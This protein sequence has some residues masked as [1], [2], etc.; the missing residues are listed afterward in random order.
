MN[1]KIVIIALIIV[2]VGGLVVGGIVFLP[3]L[4]NKS[5]EPIE[6]LNNSINDD[7]W[8]EE[9]WNLEEDNYDSWS[10]GIDL[11]I[12]G[13]DLAAPKTADPLLSTSAN[14]AIDYDQLTEEQREKIMLGE[15]TM[16][17]LIAEGLG[18]SQ[19]VSSVGD[20]SSGFDDLFTSMVD[21]KEGFNWDTL[22]DDVDWGSPDIDKG[23]TL[24]Q[25]E[26]PTDIS[27][28]LIGID[29]TLGPDGTVKDDETCPPD[30]GDGMGGPA[31]VEPDSGNNGGNN[32]DGF[33][34][35]N[36]PAAIDNVPVVTNPAVQTGDWRNT[37]PIPMLMLLVIAFA[38][39]L[40]IIGFQRGKNPNE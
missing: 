28:S 16:D 20:N 11:D 26:L 3:Q 33:N 5:E 36:I 29:T 17:D 32:G 8:G 23:N 9:D 31:D 39:I 13:A 2:V 37:T 4:L 10:D 15:L 6:Q 18:N 25:A 27:Q 30:N 21:N 40:A 19:M 7:G 14:L 34:K 12:G 38:G 24:D 1:K 22:F 35:D